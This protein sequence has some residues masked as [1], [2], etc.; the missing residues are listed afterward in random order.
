MQS[1]TAQPFAIPNVLL[2]L[3]SPDSTS[4]YSAEVLLAQRLTFRHSFSA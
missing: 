2:H 1:D 3:P 4:A